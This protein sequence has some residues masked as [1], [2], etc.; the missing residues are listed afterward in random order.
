LK[1]ERARVETEGASN[2]Q[3]RSILSAIDVMYFLHLTPFLAELEPEDLYDLAR[4]AEERCVEP[5]HAICDRSD[6]GADTLIVLLRGRVAVVRPSAGRSHGGRVTQVLGRGDVFGEL[7]VIDGSPRAV[8]L[9]SVGGPVPFLRIPG[10]S[11]RAIL[12]R[13]PRASAKRGHNT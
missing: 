10:E 4:S 8:Y 11:L 6:A 2:E 5:P 3:V 9:R 7:S 13:R 1:K 12:H